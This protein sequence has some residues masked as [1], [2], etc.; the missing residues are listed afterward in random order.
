MGMDVSSYIRRQTAR[1]VVKWRVFGDFVSAQEAE[2]RA[3]SSRLSVPIVH[4]PQHHLRL[5]VHDGQIWLP[6]EVKSR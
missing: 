1:P 3:A 2:Q 5:T 6:G 4:D